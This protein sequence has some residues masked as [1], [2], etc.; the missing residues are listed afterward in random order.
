MSG[1][2]ELEIGDNTTI[3][4]VKE[5]SQQTRNER[6]EESC[7]EVENAQ[8]FFLIKNNVCPNDENSVYDSTTNKMHLI[9]RSGRHLENGVMIG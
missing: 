1:I 7:V 5:K 3:L 9:G 6:R 4:R 8:F 2:I